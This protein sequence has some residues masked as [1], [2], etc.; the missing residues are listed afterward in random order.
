MEAFLSLLTPQGIRVL[1]L[2][3]VSYFAFT[4]PRLNEDLN[5]ALDLIMASREEDR[6]TLRLDLRGSS[7]RAVSLSYVIPTPV[8]KVSYRLDL[9]GDT[10][11]LQGWAIVDND[12]DNDWEG[13]ELSLVTGRPVSFIQNLYPPYHLSRPVLPLAIAGIAEGRTYDS[14][15]GGSSAKTASPRAASPQLMMRESAQVEYAAEG[16][17]AADSEAPRPVPAPNLAGGILETA[18]GGDAGDQFEFTLRQ[19]VTLPRQQSAMLPLVEG[20]V[21]AERTLVFDGAR[22]LGKGIIH[23]AISAELTNTTGMKLPAGPITVFDGG[24][25]AGDALIS[26]FPEQEKRLISYGEDLS[27]NGS[28]ETGA[29]TRRVHTVTINRGVMT[30]NRKAVSERVYTFKNSSGEDKRL[31]L[32]HPLT[33]A[34]TLIEPA[35]FYERTDSLY[36]FELTLKAGEERTVAVREERPLAEGIILAQLRP[37][38]FVSYVSNQEIPE[39]IRRALQQGV[40]LRQQAETARAD[41]A[42][43]EARLTRLTAEQDRIRQNLEAAGNQTPQGQEYLRRMA[44]LDADID[45]LNGSIAGAEEKVRTA[46]GA[47][48]SYLAGLSL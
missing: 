31:I 33:A 48:E 8:W 46:Q 10:P 2:E 4:D 16:Y 38:A 42:A 6:R 24:L 43:L 13:V 21:T 32:E 44:L 45:T 7:S 26:F 17:A 41:L 35:S 25:Y 20:T 30:I 47:F 19:P 29:I 40:E 18:R 15:T 5:R 12:G 39:G 37:D 3:E 22:A 34:A 11:L 36:R 1:A 9:R 28:V 14:G 23:P 27:V